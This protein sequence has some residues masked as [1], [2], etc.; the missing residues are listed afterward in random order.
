MIVWCFPLKAELHCCIWLGSV[1]CL[2]DL[3]LSWKATVT[4]WVPASHRTDIMSQSGDHKVIRI[5]QIKPSNMKLSAATD[6]DHHVV[7]HVDSFFLQRD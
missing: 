2:G 6:F 7:V 3:E 4:F 1:S 5:S